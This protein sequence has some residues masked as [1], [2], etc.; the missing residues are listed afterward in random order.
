MQVV[1][2]DFIHSSWR[3]EGRDAI[4]YTNSEKD[5][6]ISISSS[7]KKHCDTM[8]ACC[9]RNCC[10]GGVCRFCTQIMA[11]R[12]ERCDCLHRFRKGQTDL[13]LILSKKYCDTRIAYFMRNQCAGSVC[14]SVHDSWRQ[15]ERDS[16]VYTNSEKDRQISISSSPKYIATQASHIVWEIRVRVVCMVLYTA[17]GNRVREM[18]SLYKLRKR[19]TGLDHILSKNLLR[20]KDRILCEKY[21]CSWCGFCTQLMAT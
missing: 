4:V 8:I 12:G 3:Q 9:V 1:C 14:G 13:N 21:V 16:I 19:E 17:H 6:H 11:T 20:Y 7:P 2:V 18:R 10:A 15:Q 5:R